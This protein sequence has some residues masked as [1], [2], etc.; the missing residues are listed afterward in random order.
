M[1]RDYCAMDLAVTFFI[2]IIGAS[3]AAHL[4]GAFLR[5]PLAVCA[6]FFAV[7]VGAACAIMI[8]L[9]LWYR[10]SRNKA[11]G[12]FPA[13]SAKGKDTVML[14]VILLFI[15]S[16]AVF[17]IWGKGVYR[18][19]DMTVETVGSFLRSGSV[20]GLNPLTG[21]PYT[22]GMPFRCKVLC[23]PTL[24]AVLGEALS[25]EPAVLVRRV[26][27]VVMLLL[28][29]ASYECL[30]RSL[31]P[32]NRSKRLLFLMI[33]ALL[34]WVGDYRSGM[35]GFDLLRAGWRGV[36][37]RNTVLVPYTISL[38][39]RRKYIHGVL[40]CLAEMCLVW[41]GFG[42]GACAFV[43]AGLVLAQLFLSGRK[44]ENR[45]GEDGGK[46]KAV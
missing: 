1:R 32:D 41:T 13:S 38:C 30:A 34:I 23:L 5:K 25:L 37:I 6:V 21:N 19:G 14:V 16:Q 4:L 43:M 17:I 3:E 26:I 18:Q 11:I 9:C 31:F 27:P 45:A 33:T 24:Y 42:L 12:R 44:S 46:E 10:K 36:T 35:D 7:A 40:C 28:C 8:L 15:L 39:L 29:Y 20:Y 22:A 2:L